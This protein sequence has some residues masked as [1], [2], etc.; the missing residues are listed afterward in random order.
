[1]NHLQAMRVF[2]KVAENGSFRRAATSLDLSNAVVTRYVALSATHPAGTPK[3]AAVASFLLFGLTPLLQRYRAQHP[4]VKLSVTLLRRPVD[5]IE[6]GF[7]VGIMVPGQVSSGTLI[8]RSLFRGR[9]IAVASHGYIGANGMPLAP[10]SLTT[11]MFLTPS[12][13]LHNS[14]WSFVA[15]DGREETVTLEPAYPVNNAVMLREGALADM[16]ITTLPENQVAADLSDETLVRVSACYQIRGADKE[17]SLV[18]PAGGTFLQK[19][20]RSSISPSTTSGQK[21]CLHFPQY[22]KI[23]NCEICIESIRNG[24]LCFG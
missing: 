4:K 6:E 14:Q 7:D 3:L 9:A 20:D 19:P 13:N 21:P 8:K 2:L 18:Y 11:H 17:V 23:L 10:A 5:L 15:R 22:F 16:G 12:A 1:M 24:A